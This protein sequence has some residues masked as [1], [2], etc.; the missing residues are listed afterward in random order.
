M[1]KIEAPVMELRPLF[2]SRYI[3]DCFVICAT[4]A[5]MDKCFDLL[6][7][8]HIKLARE[9]PQGNWLPFLNIQVGSSNGT[10]QT[11]WY[12]KPSNKNI[13]VHFLSAHPFHMK[14]A[15]LNNMFRTARTVCSGPEERK[16]SLTLA[17]EIAVSNGYEI[18]TSETRRYRSERARQLENLTTDKIPLCFPYISDE[19]SAAIRRCL[20]KADFY[21]SVSVVEIPPNNLKRQLV[22]NRY[23]LYN[24]EL[25]YLSHR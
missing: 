8:E 4:Q 5:E 23:H 13:L 25:Y 16:E 15:V 14:K 12:H 17:H 3:D 24:T 22:R 21:S 11:K 10:Y 7:S 19:V 2:Y 18:R 1:A 20:R 6:K 9:K